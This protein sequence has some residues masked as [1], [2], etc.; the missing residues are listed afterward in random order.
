MN[1][2]E[3][4]RGNPWL[5][6]AVMVVSLALVIWLVSAA[7]NEDLLWFVRSFDEQPTEVVLY[8][9][10]EVYHFHPGD[11]G[12]EAIVS[13]FNEG[14]GDWS[15]YEG[16]VGISTE[17]LDHLR[18]EGRLL[19]LHYDH[20][21][22]VH[23]KRLYPAAITFYVPLSGTHAKWRRVFGGMTEPPHIGVLEMSEENFRRLQEVVTAAIGG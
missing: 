7:V 8:W 6:F 18:K 20:A 19:E 4:H 5:A 9:D 17:S 23:T 1:D 13:A 2:V 10:G 16:S 21:V 15:A 3:R 22:Q 12:F 11:A 14:I